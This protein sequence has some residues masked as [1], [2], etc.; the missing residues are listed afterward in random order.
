MIPGIYNGINENDYLWDDELIN[1]IRYKELHIHK[2]V[3]VFSNISIIPTSV[4]PLTGLFDLTDKETCVFGSPKI[5][6]DT[7]PS[8]T[9]D[10]KKYLMTTD[11]NILIIKI[12]NREEEAKKNKYGL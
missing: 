7:I 2:N 3:I 6:L 4:N 5:F 11:C 9:S 10:Y 8:L 1:Y 12:K